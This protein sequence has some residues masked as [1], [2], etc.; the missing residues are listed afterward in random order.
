MAALPHLRPLRTLALL[1]LATLLWA[2]AGSARA[3]VYSF[4]AEDGS[5]HFS[6]SPNDPRYQLLLRVASDEAPATLPASAT[7]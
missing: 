7:A 4:V 1:C 6:D 2:S 5:T 3:D